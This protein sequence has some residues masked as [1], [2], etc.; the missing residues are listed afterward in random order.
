MS[1]LTDTG[2]CEVM[3]GVGDHVDHFTCVVDNM[4][5][6]TMIP[7]WDVYDDKLISDL[8][9]SIKWYSSSMTPPGSEERNVVVASYNLDDREVYLIWDQQ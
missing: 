6:P 1:L 2:Y 7:Y 8:D 5:D 3:P 4:G 9:D